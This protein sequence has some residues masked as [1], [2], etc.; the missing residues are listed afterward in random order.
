MSRRKWK[1]LLGTLLVLVVFFVAMHRLMRDRL[2]QG[3]VYP[4]YST[5][6]ADPLGSKAFYDA[7]ESTPGVE[8]S[9][10]VRP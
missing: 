1:L 7:L 3:D 5:L 10:Y 4:P 8:V 9:R 6:R 2:D